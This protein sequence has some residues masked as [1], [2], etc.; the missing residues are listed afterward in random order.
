M[1]PQA[2]VS[3]AVYDSFLELIRGVRRGWLDRGLKLVQEIVVTSVK[4]GHC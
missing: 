4:S 1:V 2:A 3:Y